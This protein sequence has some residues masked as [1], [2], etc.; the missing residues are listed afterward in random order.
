MV[1]YCLRF[2]IGQVF[3]VCSLES[4]CILEKRKADGTDG[5]VYEIGSVN[6]T[7]I[8]RM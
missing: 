2:V 7:Q 5:S 6:I 1:G 4:Q 8:N 3:R